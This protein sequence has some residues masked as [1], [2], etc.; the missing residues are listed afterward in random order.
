MFSG[1][2][3]ATLIDFK[4]END[5]TSNSST[6][7]ASQSSIKA[8]VDSV[9]SG[10]DVKKSCKVATTGNINLTGTQT[11]DGI[12]ISADEGISQKSKYRF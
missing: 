6:S 4:N 11:I 10:L 7:V 2:G 9:A 5:F 8:Y 3:T 1:S 12:S